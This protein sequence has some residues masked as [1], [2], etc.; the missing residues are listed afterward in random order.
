MENILYAIN[1]VLHILAAVACAAAPFYQLRMVNERG[2]HGRAIIYGYDQSI[3]RILSVQPRLCFAF[4][5]VLIVTGFAFPVIYYAFH[6]HWRETSSLALV[7]FTVKTALVCGGFSIVLYG[8]LKIDPKVQALFA[9][10]KPDE[11]PPKELLDEFWAWRAKRKFFCK[12][13]FWLA[14]AI[15]VVTPLLRFY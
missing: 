14:V 9:R 13:C 7:A 2:K 1:L 11:Q 12:I 4:I 5:V 10:I 6:G 15:L 3:E 8:M